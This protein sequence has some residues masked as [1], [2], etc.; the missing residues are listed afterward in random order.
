MQVYAGDENYEY[1]PPFAWKFDDDSAPIALV[2]SPLH[3]IMLLVYEHTGRINM[4]EGHS[5]CNPDLRT[6]VSSPD[7]IASQ[8]G[9]N[10]GHKHL[11][12][13]LLA[14]HLEIRML[15]KKLKF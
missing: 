14:S 6:R 5:G 1:V 4:T 13:K 2:C 11:S 8:Y 3:A 15:A 10:I 7:A 9:M 12:P